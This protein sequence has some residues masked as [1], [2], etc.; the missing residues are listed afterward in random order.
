[1]QIRFINLLAFLAILFLSAC[2]QGSNDEGPSISDITTVTNST[3][4]TSTGDGLMA[5]GSLATTDS[6][7]QFPLSITLQQNNSALLQWSDSPSQTVYFNLQVEGD[8][9]YSNQ[10]HITSDQV[11]Y[12]DSNLMNN[13]SY[14]YTLSAYDQTDTIISRCQSSARINVYTTINS[15]SAE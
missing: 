8:N 7:D 12:L 11:S 14:T 15:D 1:M 6:V 4:L 9:G 5:G 2:Q 13:V 3:G 10:H